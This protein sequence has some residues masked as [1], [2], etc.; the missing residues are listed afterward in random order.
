MRNQGWQPQDSNEHGFIPLRSALPQNSHESAADCK[1]RDQGGLLEALTEDINLFYSSFIHTVIKGH[2][3]QTSLLH[4][5]QGSFNLSER[6]KI[7]SF[8]IIYICSVPISNDYIATNWNS[9][10]QRFFFSL[11]SSHIL[12][13]YN[14]SIVMP[15]P[16]SWSLVLVL[17]QAAFAS[18]T[19]NR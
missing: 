19:L 10:S 7:F 4:C 5:K 2:P 12:R 3:I 6:L 18:T 17:L 1:T 15:K 16:L 9:N 14:K 13:K 8:N 11:Q